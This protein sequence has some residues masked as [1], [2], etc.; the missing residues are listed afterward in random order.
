MK[1]LILLIFFL[2][3]RVSVAQNNDADLNG[4]EFIGT[5]TEISNTDADKL[6]LVFND[7]L[8]F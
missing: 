3:I 1:V 7:I 5:V 6:P 8:R 4:K 2:A